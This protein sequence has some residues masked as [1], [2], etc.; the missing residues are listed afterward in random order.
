MTL[1]TGIHFITDAEYHADPAP[2]PSLSSTLAKEIL[3]KSPRHAFDICARVN[4]DARVIERKTFD[5]GKAA[6]T[7]IL[8]K[9]AAWAVYPPD[10][11]A[12]NGAA[13]TK[14]AKEWEADTRAAGLTPIKAQDEEAVLAMQ[15]VA[16]AALGELDIC[17]AADRSEVA[18]LAQID[19]VWCRAL[20]DNAPKDPRRPLY[21]FKTCESANPDACKRAIDAYGY[22]VQAAHYLEVWKAATGEDRQF[23]FIFQEKGSPHEVCAVS[24]TS[25]DLALARKMTARA[26]EVWGQCVRSGYWPGYPRVIHQ[27]ELAA[28]RHENWLNRE[29]AEAD[30]RAQTGR[31]VLDHARRWQAPQA[32][33]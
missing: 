10:V 18:A 8:G 31:D 29:A 32:A 30:Y 9:G 25:D 14:A 5:I 24:L 13:S 7:A 6:H 21:D 15:K 4:P 16:E 3:G 20:I 27:I 2:E 12:S 23:V 22:D 26:R 1:T 19:G 33:E 11:L 17:L 28:W